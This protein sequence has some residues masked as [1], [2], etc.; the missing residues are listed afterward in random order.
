ML[1][2]GYDH[3][4]ITKV[5]PK[6]DVCEK[7]YVFN[8]TAVPARVQPDR[9]LSGNDPAQ[10]AADGLSGL[11]IDLRGCLYQRS[12]VV[13]AGAQANHRRHQGGRS[14]SE[15]S[16][17]RARGERVPIEPPSLNAD[18]SVTVTGRMGRIN[19]PLGRKM[20]AIDADKA[21]KAQA[22]QQRAAAKQQ[23]EAD[24]AAAAAAAKAPQQAPAEAPAEAVV[25]PTVTETSSVQPAD[26]GAGTGVLSSV[27][28]KLGNLFG[29]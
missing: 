13:Q 26:D 28:K 19:S 22:A 2:A 18:G 21:A 23:A 20:A 5:P 27:R 9:R 24:K 11:P 12:D 16:R 7:R 6:V 10:F 1:K 25:Q 4:E 15:W 8:Q 3:F 14:V 17:A 29:G